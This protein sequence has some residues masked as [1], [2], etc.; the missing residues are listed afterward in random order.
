MVGSGMQAFGVRTRVARERR[1]E[2]LVGR[3]GQ[4]GRHGVASG[5]P[6]GPAGAR[7][8]ANPGGRTA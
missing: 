4:R 5:G 2:H 8:A 3:G 7:R 6:L 1:V